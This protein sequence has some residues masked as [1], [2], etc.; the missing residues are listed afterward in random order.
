MADGIRY[1][2]LLMLDLGYVRE[3]LDV[4]ERMARDRGITL[5]L[6]PF[7]EIDKERRLLIRSAELLKAER[8]KASDEIARLKKR[9]KTRRPSSR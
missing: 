8:N 7:R 9:S 3:H 5:D 6:E 1:A 2:S 4:I